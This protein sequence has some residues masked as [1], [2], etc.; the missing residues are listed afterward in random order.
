MHVK[1]V[2]L[3]FEI[4]WSHIHVIFLMTNRRWV[5]TCTWSVKFLNTNLSCVTFLF[6]NMTGAYTE[7]TLKALNKIYLIDLL[8]EMQ[9]QTN[10]T[11]DSLMV[12][13]KDL[14]NSFKRLESAVQIIKSVNNS[15]LKQLECW[16]AMPANAQYSRR[17]LVEVIGIPKTVESMDLEHTVC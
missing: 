15:L 10:S 3:V 12:E 1:L 6:E 8:L 4:L 11:I 9:D 13:M 5:Q 7:D 16:R 2:L 14:N 17:E